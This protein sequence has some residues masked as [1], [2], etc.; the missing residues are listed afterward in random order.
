MLKLKK[1]I[2][3]LIVLLVISFPLLLSGCSD[4]YYLNK[5][6]NEF[7]SLS[8]LKKKYNVLLEKKEELEQQLLELENNIVFKSKEIKEITEEINNLKVELNNIYSTFNRIENTILPGAVMIVRKGYENN[9]WW[10]FDYYEYLDGSQG[11]GTIIK[12]DSKY[13]YVLTNYH[14]ISSEKDTD[15]DVFYVY[16]YRRTKYEATL[17]HASE[18]YDMAIIKFKKGQSLSVIPLAENKNPNIGETVY[19]IAFPGGQLNS[20]SA[21]KVKKYGYINIKDKGQSN[22]EVLEANFYAVGGSSGSM[23]LNDKFE[24]VGILTWSTNSISTSINNYHSHASPIEKIY[25]FFNQKGF[26]L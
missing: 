2:S 25:E 17:V 13:Y 26:K 10:I 21:G 7:S 14:V 1:Y 6:V 19:S 9:G 18:Y 5:P 23:V 24:I 11:S 4:K 16:D 22:Y 8:L 12:E 3:I 20:V 15:K